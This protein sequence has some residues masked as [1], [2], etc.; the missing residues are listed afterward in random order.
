MC[1]SPETSMLK[2]LKLKKKYY[3]PLLVSERH[4][5]KADVIESIRHDCALCQV[6]ILGKHKNQAFPVLLRKLFNGTIGLL[7]LPS[8]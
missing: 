8:G 3:K 2:M 6:C 1:F 4:L 7:L 5:L